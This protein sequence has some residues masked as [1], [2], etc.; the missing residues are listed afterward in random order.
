MADM[1]VNLYDLPEIIELEDKSITIKRALAPDAIAIKEFARVN[2]NDH[3]VGEVEAALSR[4]NPTCFIA[5]KDKKVIGF[6]CFEATAP[7]MF[8]PTGVQAEYRGL[9]IGKVLLLKCLYV[10]FAPF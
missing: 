1:L 4:V 2:F 5:V 7:S 10:S 9:G 3:W 6:A 8:G